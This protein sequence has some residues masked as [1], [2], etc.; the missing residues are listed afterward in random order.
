VSGRFAGRVAVVTGAGRGIGRAIAL[1]LAAE[2]AGVA[3][4]DVDAESA[5]RT[6]DEIRMLGSPAVAVHVDVR[7]R[8][9]VDALIGRTV[10]SLGRLDILV[11]NAGISHR[12]D[13]TELPEEVWDEI[14]DV[15]LK[16]VFLCGQAAAREMARV[17]RGAIVNVASQRGVSASP[18]SAAYIASKG[19]VIALTRA[20]AVDLAPLGIRVNAVGPGPV[21]TDL[22]RHRFEDRTYREE[23]QARVP[24]GRLGEPEDVVGAVLFLAGEEARWVTGHCLFVD[25]GWVAS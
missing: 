11:S 22:N 7:R 17:G 4:A 15:N 10:A 16:G 3:V 2:G 18:R 5:E 1:A 13:F 19:G 21:I 14:I 24:L 23:T 25:G 6:S 12:H 8:D 20:M 9:E